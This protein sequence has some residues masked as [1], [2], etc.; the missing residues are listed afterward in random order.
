MSR[1]ER[2]GGE[3]EVRNQC[4]EVGPIA[5]DPQRGLQREEF[6][7]P[8]AEGDRPSQ[9]PDCPLGLVLGR[10]LGAATGLNLVAEG[11]PAGGGDPVEG[12]ARV[13]RL[14]IAGRCIRRGR[15]VGAVPAT[16]GGCQ[17]DPA[18]RALAAEI[19]VRGGCRD[20]RLQ[21]PR[22]RLE[23]GDGRVEFIPERQGTAPV[24]QEG[25]SLAGG[26]AGDECLPVGAA[27]ERVEVGVLVDL[28]TVRV[29]GGQ[30]LP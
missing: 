15:F 10:R 12:I 8:E 27:A 22:G 21:G 30:G 23:L 14:E 20:E 1:A 5:E 4:P 25:P 18:E 11:V 17:L 26:Q 3:G 7:V 19:K 2:V 13:V 6:G 29:A 9:G 16:T 28:T 24:E